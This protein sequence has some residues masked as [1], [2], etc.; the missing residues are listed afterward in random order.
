V[1][2]SVTKIIFDNVL[3]MSHFAKKACQTSVARQSV[4]EIIVYNIVFGHT[5]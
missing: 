1:Q 5:L 4:T 3:Y 2:Q